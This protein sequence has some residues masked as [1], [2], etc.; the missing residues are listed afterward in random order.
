MREGRLLP[1]ACSKGNTRA[2]GELARAAGEVANAFR[3]IVV[4]KYHRQANATGDVLVNGR[5]G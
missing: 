4:I 2:P 5:C 3:S 1:A